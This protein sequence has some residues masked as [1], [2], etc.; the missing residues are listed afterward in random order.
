MKNERA[1]ELLDEHRRRAFGTEVAEEH[2]AGVDA[3]L[4]RPGE[5]LHRVRLVFDRDRAVDE[6]ELRLLR[7]GHDGGDA[8]LGE[9]RGEAVAADADECELNDRLIDHFCFPLI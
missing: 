5:R 8:L 6:C 9:G 2:A 1:L 7:L 3:F 4:A